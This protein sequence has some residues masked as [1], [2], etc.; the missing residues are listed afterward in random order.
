M[1][2]ILKLLEHFDELGKLDILKPLNEGPAFLLIMG[3]CKIVKVGLGS[4]V[5]FFVVE[6]EV[7]YDWLDVSEVLDEEVIEVSMKFELFFFLVEEVVSDLLVDGFRI[8]I[9]E[10]SEVF[11]ADS[12]ADRFFELFF[13]IEK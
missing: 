11:E 3:D 4:G 5:L 8:G 6:R 9:T 2:L 7:V 1:I 13:Y 12:F 10:N